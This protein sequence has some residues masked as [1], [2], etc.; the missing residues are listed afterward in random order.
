MTY[1]LKNNSKTIKDALADLI[2]ANSE[3][4]DDQ[5]VEPEAEVVVPLPKAILRKTDSSGKRLA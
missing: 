5:P 4:N 2:A 1:Y 3:L